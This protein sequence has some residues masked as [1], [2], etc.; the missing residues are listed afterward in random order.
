MKLEDIVNSVSTEI[1]PQDDALTK[2]FILQILGFFYDDGYRCNYLLVNKGDIGQIKRIFK[3]NR[4][5]E[6]GKY[7]YEL[8]WGYTQILQNKEISPRNVLVTDKY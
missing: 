5:S 4:K 6:V 1:N 2:S 8:D 3:K 7:T